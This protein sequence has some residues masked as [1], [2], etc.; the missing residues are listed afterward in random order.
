VK[1]PTWHFLNLQA[2][3]FLRLTTFTMQ[4]GSGFEPDSTKY[5]DGCNLQMWKW[6]KIR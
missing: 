4:S 1:Y 3:H 6:R 2:A 5:S